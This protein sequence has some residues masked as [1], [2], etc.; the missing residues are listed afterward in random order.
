[1]EI[2]IKLAIIKKECKV[3]WLAQ[4]KITS[5]SM[6][7]LAD[8]LS[9]NNTLEQLYLQ[10]NNIHDDG[11]HYLAKALSKNN[12]LKI[13]GLG[14]NGITDIGVKHLSQMMKTNKKLT[15]IWLWQNDICDEGVHVLAN[16]I[17]NHNTTL[18]VLN[19][20]E[21]VLLTDLSI[22]SLLQMIKNNTSLVELIVF[23]CNLSEVSKERL[24]KVQ[25]GKTDFKVYVNNPFD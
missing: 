14:H 1:M 15:E 4:N 5:V 11:V 7:I 10:Y 12:T 16:A 23:N 25:E 19:L 22:I 21:N 17:E 2:V 8:A 9:D 24:K 13:L 6:S 20:R 18:Q 3:L